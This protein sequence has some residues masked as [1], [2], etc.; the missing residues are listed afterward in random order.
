MS[1]A[2]LNS[3][4][5]CCLC[6]RLEVDSFKSKKFDTVYRNKLFSMTTWT[7]PWAY[8]RHENYLQYNY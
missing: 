1:V 6:I 4:T 7:N 5:L 8:I 3:T 2:R